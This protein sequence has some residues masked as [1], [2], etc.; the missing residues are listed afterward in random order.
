MGSLIDSILDFKWIVLFYSLIFVLVYV[1]RKRFEIHLGV[2]A[3]LKTRFGIRLMSS[4]GSRYSRLIRFLGYIG[5]IV[6]FV[7]MV[8]VVGFIFFGLYL[9]L[10]VPDS[11]ATISPVIPGVRVPGTTFFI[12]FWQGIVC[13]FIVAVVHEFGHGIVAA[14]NRVQVKSTGPFILGP[15]FGAFV[16]PDEE[17]LQKKHD[18][19]QYSIYAAGP[20]FN[21]M[22]AFL[23][24]IVFSFVLIP[25]TPNLFEPVGVS[26]SDFAPGGPAD[27]AGLEKN[28]VYGSFNGREIR[29]VAEFL[30]FADTLK[31][32]DVVTVGDRS[33]RVGANPKD[34][35]EPFFGVVGISNRYRNDDSLAFSSYR[36][37]FEIVYFIFIL[38]L[39]IGTANLLP[40][41]PID[42][43]RMI[44]LPLQ[45][46]FGK[47]RGKMIW[48]RVSLAFLLIIVF[49]MTPVLRETLKLL[50][51][52]LA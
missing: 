43:G 12:P 19:V 36:F 11:P 23:A 49:L 22:L 34:S 31:P 24:F 44:L 42:G 13:I 6:G 52:L 9:V 18:I 4:L 46:F 21:F 3:I 8:A 33:L 39:G 20:F 26:F 45:R 17:S 35:S 47:E 51:K 30:E 38:S 15:F 10:F 5:I 1:F 48:G 32:G 37:V 40:L 28:K 50:F 29:N 25:L 16:E 27:S 2:F 41:G 14:A 7:A